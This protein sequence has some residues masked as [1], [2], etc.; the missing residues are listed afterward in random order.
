MRIG[1]ISNSDQF[2]PLAYTLANNSLQVCIFF[3]PGEDSYVHQKVSAFAS[4][5][6]LPLVNGKEVEDV[7]TWISQF[8]PDVVFVYG[9]RHLLDVTK[10]SGIPVFNIH[11]GALPSFRGPVPVFWQ[12]KKGVSHLTLSIHVLSSRFDD[13]TV[14][15]M[16]RIPDQPHY[17]YALVHHVFS[18][19]VIE[20]VYFI[21]HALAAKLPLPAITDPSGMPPAY[22]KRPVSEDVLIN[23][24]QM[25]ATVICNLVRA[26]NPWNK[27]AST[28]LDGQEVKLMDAMQTGMET[29]LS[30]GT[31]SREGTHLLIATADQQLLHINMLQLHDTF[32][33]AYQAAYYGIEPGKRLGIR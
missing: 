5:S 25:P 19:L 7:Y 20:G 12:L 16:Q 9:F 4:A 1:I 13:G 32:V 8:K 17:N 21:L 24:E 3:T 15:W 18:Q 10:F 31:V 26:C 23:W 14:V 33:P 30:P 6:R 29:T 22:H 11:P 2:I 27:G 28:I